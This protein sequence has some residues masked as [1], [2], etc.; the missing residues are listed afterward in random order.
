[1]K[2]APIVIALTAFA[3]QFAL[4]ETALAPGQATAAIV[5][6][7]A[8]PVPIV[9]KAGGRWNTFEISAKG[10]ELAVKFNGVVT[11]RA[12][13]NLHASGPFALQFGVGV[14]G[15]ASGPI[16]WRKVQIRSL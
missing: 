1:M 8:V 9:Y 3:A 7:A 6:V 16:K 15:A 10:A 12:Q 14:K 11:A 4:A 2:L 5:N 13:N